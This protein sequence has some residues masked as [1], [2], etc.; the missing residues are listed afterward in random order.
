MS[1][2]RGFVT[3]SGLA[4]WAASVAGIAQ[5]QRALPPIPFQVG[6]PFPNLPLPSLDG[7]PASI[8]DFRGKKLILHVFASW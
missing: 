4:A 1:L 3:A 6:Q 7:R 2:A 5:A 8:A